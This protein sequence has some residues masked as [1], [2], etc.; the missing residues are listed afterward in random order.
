VPRRPGRR[1]QYDG[2]GDDQVVVEDVDERG[3]QAAGA[4][5][6]DGRAGDD[7]VGF[8]DGR[9]RRLQPWGDDLRY[10]RGAYIGGDLAQFDDA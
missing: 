1:G 3:E 6:V 7:P 2:P 10:Q 9:E 8:A 5:L 4:G